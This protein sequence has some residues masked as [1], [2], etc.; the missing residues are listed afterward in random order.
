M[1]KKIMDDYLFCIN[2]SKETEHEI[3][4]HNN[5]IYSIECKE[6][7]MTVQI[8]QE[9]VREHFKEE[10]TQRVLTKPR[11]ITQEL[12]SDLNGFLKSLP[13]RI[14]TKPYRVYKE[15]EEIEKASKPEKDKK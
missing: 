3:T 8:N 14:I 7:G 15:W 10:F 1:N 2:C 9:Y 13:Y 6:C 12:Q 5:Q 4:Y 11:R